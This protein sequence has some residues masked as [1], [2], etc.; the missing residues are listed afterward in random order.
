METK[1]IIQFF[2]LFPGL[3]VE[4][5]AA[6]GIKISSVYF[7]GYILYETSKGAID[8]SNLFKSTTETV[9]ELEELEQKYD[10]GG[11]TPIMILSTLFNADMLAKLIID[12]ETNP[13]F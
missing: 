5:V 9:F 8:I 3:K 11:I 6:T 1:E 10:K 12:I 4:A 2:Q 13:V 7:L